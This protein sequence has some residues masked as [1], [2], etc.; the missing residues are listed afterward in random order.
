M[1][2]RLRV[3]GLGPTLALAAATA[4]WGSTFFLSKGLVDRHDPMSMLAVRFAIAGLV[5]LAVRP[6]C[7][8]GLDRGVWIRATGLGVV[9]ALAQIPQHYGLRDSSA[10]L[11]GVL[12]G[13]YVA[14]VPVMNWLLLRRRTD[15]RTLIGVMLALLALATL[16]LGGDVV[17]GGGEP[18]VLLA[19]VVYA[20]QVV[21][22]GLWSR[23]GEA[24][25]L[26][27]IQM[28]AIAG[29]LGVNAAHRGWD[30]PTSGGDWWVILYLAV[31]ASA[32]CVG[33]QTWAQS[34]MSASRAG[35]ILAA[36]PMWAA[37]L[38]VAFTAELLTGRLVLGGLILLLANVV[39]VTRRR[40]SP[41]PRSRPPAKAKGPATSR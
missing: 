19:A 1:N 32:L 39:I 11:A 16:S 3:V 13:A 30:L 23:P 20:V 37:G 36:E 18:L 24:Y 21:L 17:L 34:R 7:L 31:V 14:F 35:V 22:M 27:V 15:G 5:M 38:A 26:T 10:S 25:V 4:M 28:F 12:T 41:R 2:A 29:V 8:R 33:I 6:T 9:Y 40:A